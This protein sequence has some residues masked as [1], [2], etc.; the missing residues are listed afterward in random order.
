MSTGKALKILA[1]LTGAAVLFLPLWAGRPCMDSALALIGQKGKVETF[2]ETPFGEMVIRQK[3]ILS[4][5]TILFKGNVTSSQ[6]GAF[7]PFTVSNQSVRPDS[8]DGI[9]HSR[10][11]AIFIS[12]KSGED[13]AS[14]IGEYRVDYALEFHTDEQEELA[15][16]PD[17]PGLEP[18]YT[19]FTALRQIR[20][21]IWIFHNDSEVLE[22]PVRDLLVTPL[23]LDNA[24]RG[25]TYEVS[26]APLRFK[27]RVQD[28][29]RGL[30]SLGR[31][32][33]KRIKFLLDVENA[34]TFA[35]GPVE[36]PRE[37]P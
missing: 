20:L 14:D 35:G 9:E 21:K 28:I 13:Y 6:G 29:D 7:I 17:I 8:E 23:T 5:E 26:L 18:V 22:E 2:S 19:P 4:S 25:L 36:T 37:N 16:D 15:G 1:S 24:S 3:T 30:D 27:V 12:R 34:A 11:R 31:Y 10:E 32:S 33:F